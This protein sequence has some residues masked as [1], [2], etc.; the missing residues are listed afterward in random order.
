MSLYRQIAFPL[1]SRMDPESAHGRALAGLRLAASTGPGRAMLRGLAGQIPDRPVMFCGLR[2]PN[3]L[4]VAAGL[5]KNVEA[6]RALFLLGFGHVEIGTLTPRPQGGNPRPRLFRLLEHRAVINRMGFPN[7]GVEAA[8]PRLEQ[9]WKVKGPAIVGASLGKQKETELGAAAGDY[10]AVMRAVYPFSDYLA[11]NISSPNTPGLRELQGGRYL[12]E[13]CGTLASESG[14]LARRHGLPRR[15]VLV[16]IAPDLSE[17]ELAEIVS[18]V[19][20]VGID[21]L[22]AT[23]TTLS[24]EAVAGH[25][26]AAEAGGL[27]GPPVATRSTAVIAR[28]RELS[29]ESVPIIGVGGVDSADSAGEKLAAGASL[30]QLYTAMVYQGPGLAGGILRGLE[31]LHPPEKAL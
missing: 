8:L 26:L 15:P 18:I 9:L 4:G 16:K 17:E 28:I 22:I 20:R 23:N 6:T 10:L 2:F 19:Q 14:E 3:V 13:L 30:V 1:I 7:C 31:S 25:P 12:E 5:D 29:G 21:G 11:V 27:S 24:R